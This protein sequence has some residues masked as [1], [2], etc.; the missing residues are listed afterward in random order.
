MALKPADLIECPFC[1]GPGQEKINYHPFL[2]GWVGC[3]KCMVY[4]NWRNHPSDR[5]RA[6]RTW[7]TRPIEEDLHTRLMKALKGEG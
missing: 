3:K 4:I 5:D 2:N 6:I 7:N 1:N